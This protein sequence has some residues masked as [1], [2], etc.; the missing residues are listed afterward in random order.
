M[1]DLGDL[2][3][4]PG[5]VVGGSRDVNSLALSSR[6]N[7]VYQLERLQRMEVRRR[8]DTFTVVSYSGSFIT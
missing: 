1:P 8:M 2:N 4:G 3:D 5:G 7:G 6:T